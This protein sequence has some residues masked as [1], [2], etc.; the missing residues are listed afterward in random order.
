[1]LYQNQR[2]GQDSNVVSNVSHIS[3]NVHSHRVDSNDQNEEQNEELQ[4][5][6]DQN[7]DSKDPN[8]QQQLNFSNSR[9]L[10]SEDPRRMTRIKSKRDLNEKTG[11]GKKVVNSKENQLRAIQDNLLSVTQKNPR[12]ITTDPNIQ[13]KMKNQ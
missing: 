8:G 2:G 1:M 7:S 11:S 13:T 9:N 4:N 12:I 5:R 6:A 10:N 3:S